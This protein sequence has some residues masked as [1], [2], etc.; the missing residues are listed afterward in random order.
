MKIRRKYEIEKP[1]FQ[2]SAIF[3]K[4]EMPILSLPLMRLQHSADGNFHFS[5][6]QPTF[7]S[8]ENLSYSYY[9]KSLLGGPA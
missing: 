3:K 1:L 9:S 4:I 2:F 8:Q 6:S 5:T 7:P